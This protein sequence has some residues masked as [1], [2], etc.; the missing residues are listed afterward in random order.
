MIINSTIEELKSTLKA[1]SK[2]MVEKSIILLD[3]YEINNK[4]YNLY[5]TNQFYRNCKK[6]KVWLNNDFLITLKNAKYGIDKDNMRSKGGKD[7]IY[8]VDRKFQPK[9]L[10]QTKIYDRFIDNANSKFKEY[11]NILVLIMPI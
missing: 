9:N 6:G 10:M 11:T 8:L 7:G 1:L 3:S 4:K 5:L 2:D